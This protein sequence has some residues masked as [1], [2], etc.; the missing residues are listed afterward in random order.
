MGVEI[1]RSTRSYVLELTIGFFGLVVLESTPVV[2]KSDGDGGGGGGVLGD[3]IIGA[4]QEL[5]RILFTPIRTV[6]ETHGDAV[7]QTVV[8]TP[9]PD[10]VFNQPTNGAWPTI[11]GYYWNTMIPLTLSL[12]ALSIGIVIF[13]ESTSHL[14]NGYHRS[15]L[16]KRAFAGLLGVLSWWWIT[17]LS[18]Q[19][20][21][22]LAK[23]LIPSVANITLFQQLSFGGMGVLGTIVALS[24]NFLLFILIGLIYLARHVA[25]YLFVLLMP[26]L[27]VFWIPGVGPFSL[28]SKFMKKLAG[29]YVP[30]LFMT[31]PVALLFR[32]GDLLGTS[33]G[34]SAGEFGAWLTALIIPLLAVVS[35]LVLF[36]QAGALFFMADRVS[37]HMSAQ[38]A[39]T[40]VSN[41][42]ERI[43]ITK[44]G[45]KNFAR[46][47]RDQPAVSTDGQ[48]LLNSGN[49]RAH[50]T[51]QRLN[52]AGSR[53]RDVLG[54]NGDGGSGGNSGNTSSTTTTGGSVNESQ[55]QHGQTYD[56]SQNDHF[57][58]P[59]SRTQ[60]HHSRD[61]QPR[62]IH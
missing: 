48:Y 25:L 21:D 34:P 53:L 42:R 39:R 49:S 52:Q 3:I 40:R 51:G 10:A 38:R 15:K 41:T 61:E 18:L 8:G 54:N 1:M 43:Q 5:L 33:I 30:F 35:P 19:F 62:Y 29:F 36:W 37:Q 23:F 44:Q 26:L 12:F 7:L 31:V 17:A 13:L 58:D 50:A 11:H 60:D 45:G 6:I 24:A 59:Q 32:L 20:M 47:V 16:K 55:S 22:A 9:H 14:F 57:R 4:I 56:R 28:V 27:I 2:A 46:G